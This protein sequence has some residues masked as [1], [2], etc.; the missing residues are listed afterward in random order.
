M[1]FY[2]GLEHLLGLIIVLLSN[3]V[4]QPRKE[5]IS[6]YFTIYVG[7][8]LVK[9]F[10]YLFFAHW[11]LTVVMVMI[12]VM[13]MVIM[14]VIMIMIVVVVVVVIMAFMGIRNEE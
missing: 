10:C 4:L 7:I 13:P 11:L 5:L 3:F 14:V 6:G 8:K 9:H 2:H 1:L 12:V